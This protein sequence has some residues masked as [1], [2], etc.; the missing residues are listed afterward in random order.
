MSCT[1]L[2]AVALV[3]QTAPPGPDVAVVCPES[4]R[5]ALAPWVR[6]RT[7][8]GHRI[9]MLS[10]AGSAEQIRDRIRQAAQGQR[11]RYAVLVGDADPRMA[12]S[13]AIRARCVPTHLAEA[14]VNVL[15]GST[16]TLATDNWYAD[17]DDDVAPDLAVGRL[18]A[19]SPE[20]LAAIVA[21]ILAYERS[22]D[23]GAWRR[24]LNFVAGVGGFSP[25]ADMVLESSARYFL[26][27][28]VPAGFDLSMTYASWRSPYCPDPRRFHQTTVERLNEGAWFWV[29]IG[30]GF[31]LGLDRVN[32]PR[33]R[34]P[35]LHVG[36]LDRLRCRPQT[37]PI[38]LFLACY[39]GAFDVRDDCLAEQM[40]RSPGGPVAIV[41]SSRVA[42][43]YGLGVMATELMDECFQRRAATLGEA[44]LAAK[45]AAL[46]DGPRGKR[47]EML[48]AIA[49]S[50]SPTGAKIAAERAEHVLLLNLI[51]DPLLRLKHPGEVHLDVPGSAG[52]GEALAVRGRSDVDGPCTVE[53]A[54][55]RGRLTFRHAG[56]RAYPESDNDLEGFQPVYQKANDLRLDQVET[57][58]EGGRFTARL[59][60]P[61]EAAGPC[62]VRAFVEGAKGF[63]LGASSV[64]IE[65]AARTAD[66]TTGRRP[67]G[68]PAIDRPR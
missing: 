26:T 54:V 68:P 30:H 48:D 32:T 64:R 67:A 20:Q 29:Y 18:P 39:T 56:R 40:L 23:F 4:L 13:P 55:E 58:V 50:L 43:P 3:A 52:R 34:Y 45:R 36:D 44:L 47:R 46:D 37:A 5:E 61:E 41:A 17:L 35:I 53:L 2:L 57:T 9:F 31:H 1:L 60:V 25:L 66:A 63:A 62:V 16:P 42:M 15:W 11:L 33:A 8:Q 38:A 51:G 7:E 28:D 6:F 12:Q 21:K 49:A 59:T 14:E 24:K 22:G 27:R 19:D 65:R 10:A